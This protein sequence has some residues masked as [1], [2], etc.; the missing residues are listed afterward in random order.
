[1]K[2]PKEMRPWKFSSERSGPFGGYFTYLSQDR[3]EQQPWMEE[4]QRC[5]NVTEVWM[6]PT[7]LS[8]QRDIDFVLCRSELPRG[9]TV[10]RVLLSAWLLWSFT[11]KS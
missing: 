1:M 6:F 5:S 9:S 2:G 8:P 4:P 3:T 11:Q 10:A 7:L